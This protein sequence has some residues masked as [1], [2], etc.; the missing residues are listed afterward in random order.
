LTKEIFIYFSIILNKL[1][2]LLFSNPD[3]GQF[4]RS[5]KLHSAQKEFCSMKH[6]FVSHVSY[7]AWIYNLFKVQTVDELNLA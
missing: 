5:R 1:V 4:E 6:Q 3:S 2:F 7:K